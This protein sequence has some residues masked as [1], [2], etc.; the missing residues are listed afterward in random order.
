[1][2]EEFGFDQRRGQRRA[3]DGDERPAR[4]W[5]EIMQRTRNQL[6]AGARLA[7]DQHG[8]VH[9]RER[10]HEFPHALD[11]AGLAK[12]ALL[13]GPALDVP[14]HPPM[15]EHEAAQMAGA[16]Q[17]FQHIGGVGG[18]FDEI[19][20]ACRIAETAIGTSAWPEMRM[21]GISA[22]WPSPL[23]ARRTRLARACAHQ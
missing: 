12:D 16:T 9:L 14:G 7:M 15:I 10:Q 8:A 13:D 4:P 3:I 17:Q 18:L 20:R 5:A 1:M 19:M 11:G 2:A 6:L 21:T 23:R 22:S